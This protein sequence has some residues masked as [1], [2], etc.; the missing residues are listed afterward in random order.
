VTISA[1]ET[2]NALVF[3]LPLLKSDAIVCLSGEDG[4]ERLK[5]A[6]A[7]MRQG[8]AQYLVISG[9]VDSESQQSAK[10]LFPKALSHAISHERIILEEKSTNTREQS[11]NVVKL[12]VEKGWRRILI[13]ASPY[14]LPR[15]QLSFIKALKESGQDESIHVLPIA[16]DHLPWFGK[17]NGSKYTRAEL[18]AGE[19][20]KIELYREHCASF[21]EG[22]AYQLQW[23]GR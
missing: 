2:F 12:A 18:F 1:R 9:G 16:A 14:H 6:A 17:P 5:F 19:M 11:V 20:G 10:T 4:E 7:L 21:E 22:L 23:E 3:N 15:A 13:V 8:G